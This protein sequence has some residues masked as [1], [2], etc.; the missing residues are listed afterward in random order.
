MGVDR[1]LGPRT[2]PAIDPKGKVRFWGR[3][4]ARAASRTPNAS[5]QAVARGPMFR[6]SR[7][8][9]LHVSD[10]PLPQ[11]SRVQQRGRSP[12]LGQVRRWRCWAW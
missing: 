4:A 2:L 9:Q 1:S 3:D 10:R 12:A 7:A 8:R 11:R 5:G 6:R